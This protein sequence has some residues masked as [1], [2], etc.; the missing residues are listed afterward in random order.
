[1]NSQ[2]LDLPESIT[3]EVRSAKATDVPAIH[4]LI[5]HWAHKDRMLLRPIDDLF[6]NLR[7]FFV[8]EDMSVGIPQIIGTGALHILWGDI[9]EIRGLAVAPKLTTRG[10]GRQLVKACEDEARFLGVPTLFAWTYAVA[11]FE[12]CG[13]TK[14]DK[15]RELHPRVWSECL[16]CTFYNNCNENGMIKQLEGVPIPEGLP[17]PPI[18]QVPPGIT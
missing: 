18:S 14:I 7:D 1:M 13:F 10:I 16:R 17:K 15:S 11:F 2:N 6:A 4:K 9:A 3:I 12:R 8:A 5:E